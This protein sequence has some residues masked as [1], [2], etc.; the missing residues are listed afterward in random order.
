MA[1]NSTI[2]KVIKK[3]KNL[4]NGLMPDDLN[5]SKKVTPQAS[6]LKAANST[7][8]AANSA[9]NK[10]NSIISGGK[11]AGS[12][13]IPNSGVQISGMAQKSPQ[14]N[15]N[16]APSNDFNPRKQGADYLNSLKK[17]QKEKQSLQ[18]T[19]QQNQNQSGVQGASDSLFTTESGKYSNYIYE[20]GSEAYSLASSKYKDP[21]AFAKELGLSEIPDSIEGVVAKHKEQQKKEE[22]FQT[23]TSAL[24]AEI[25]SES[26]EIE[27]AKGNAAIS[28]TTA[29]FAQSREGPFGSSMAKVAQGFE[30]RVQ[31]QMSI[32][33]KQ[34][35]LNQMKRDKAMDQLEEAKRNGDQ[36]LVQ[37]LMSDIAGADQSIREAESRLM[38]AQNEATDLSMKME[39]QR[40]QT[41][42]N[43][44][45]SME[46]MPMGTFAAMDP[47][48]IS[49]MLGVD[50]QTAN[51]LKAVDQQRSDLK[52][53][54]PDYLQKMANI[55]Q[56]LNEAKWAGMTQEQ[57][58]FEY[59]KNLSYSNPA[60]AEEFANATGIK[61]KSFFQDYQSELG[62]LQT[63]STAI[64][65]STGVKAPLKSK[66]AYELTPDGGISFEKSA[67]AGTRPKRGQC[68]AFVNDILN[69]GP[70]LVSDSYE[71]KKA[72][73]NSSEPVAGSAFIE[74][75]AQPWG[76]IGIVEKVYRD[77][78]GEVTGYD[79]RE[80]NFV[81]T[82]TVSVAHI[83]KGDAR[84]NRIQGF[85]V[86]GEDRA[87]DQMVEVQGQGQGQQSGGPSSDFQNYAQALASGDTDIA[88]LKAMGMSSSDIGALQTAALRIKKQSPQ[89]GGSEI[90]KYAQGLADGR[91]SLSELKALG[92]NT[93]E[94]RSIQNAS[95]DMSP[96]DLGGSSG[97]SGSSGGFDDAQMTAEIILGSGGE[98]SISDIPQDQR[99]AVQMYMNNMK[100]DPRF[101]N[102]GGNETAKKAA[103]AIFSGGST[104]TL[105]QLP[106]AL[107]VEVETELVNMR[108]KAIEEGDIQGVIRA[109]AGGKDLS[110]GTMQRFEKTANV[111]YQVENLNDALKSSE[112]KLKKIDAGPI[113]GFLKKKNPWSTD[114]QE[115]N[116][117][118]QGTIPNLARG[119]F[120]EVGVLTDRDVEL[121]RKTLPN[122]QQTED[123]Q[124]SVTALTLRTLRTSMENQIKIQAG[125]GRDVSG[126]L[127]F[128]MEIDNTVRQMETELGIIEDIQPEQ[129]EQTSGNQGLM[130]LVLG[131]GNESEFDLLD[132]DGPDDDPENFLNSFDN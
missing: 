17:S 44:F 26:F 8:G 43:A 52:M 42:M 55:E 69:G 100:D 116:A 20:K 113:V 96:S 124:K 62:E 3:T 118:L 1:I 23:K 106:Q 86:P 72:L 36:S 53:E 7:Y 132:F 15:Q 88:E 105:S 115:L 54:D 63:Q 121:Y 12:T 77:E 87:E 123:V 110:E 14:T 85:H 70:G 122:L 128:Y 126:L 94:L 103:Q 48:G 19:P 24:E 32:Q 114:A 108:K 11:P 90:M 131:S 31:K 61:E 2:N 97:S 102:S 28:A 89:R 75:V 66:Y 117:I 6:P 111:I 65:E 51:I 60:A 40:A 84:W 37:S 46:R 16:I 25:E 5:S 47:A 129:E 104:L 59:Y 38:E 35:Q 119:V 30:E 99:T 101:A 49:E 73:V 64:Y 18:Q 41:R 92:F 81:S 107:R 57:K 58:N 39:T 78:S 91:T 125:G 10:A 22:E 13:K 71:S 9:L 79:I 50:I 120:G 112:R 4:S 56:T 76:H 27:K 68:G 74:N 127:P 45:D 29:N 83:S 98:M 93:S 33:E 34:I 80:S 82:E 130:K 67:P 21:A 109:S 95:L